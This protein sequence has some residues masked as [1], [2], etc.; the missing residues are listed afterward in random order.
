MRLEQQVMIAAPPEEVWEAICDPLALGQ[1]MGPGMSVE[2]LDPDREPGLGARYR[3]LISVGAAL[4][5][6][7]VEIVEW[8]APRDL[9]WVG[10]TGVSHRLRLRVRPE[11][12]GTRLTLRFAYDAPGILGTVADL[13]ALPRVRRLL[14]EGLRAIKHEVEQGS[15]PPIRP[16]SLPS[17][18]LHELGNVAV[19]ARAGI[20]A[21]MRPDKLPRLALAAYVWGPTLATGVAVGAIRHPERPIVEDE[22]G[23]LSYREMHE[24]TDAIAC[25]LAELGIAEGDS[26]GLMARNHRGFV[27]GAIAVAKLG[28]DVLLLNTAF[29]AP[30]LKEVC[31]RERPSALIYDAEF[32]EL[33]EG[34]AKRRVRVIA[35]EPQD[36]DGKRSRRRGARSNGR[37]E[38]ARGSTRGR[39]ASTLAELRRRHAGSRPLP[40][41]R[42]GRVTILTSGTTGTPKGASRGAGGGG[43]ALPSLDAPAGLLERIPLRAGMRIGLAAPMFHAW[44]LANFALGL[45]LGATHVLAR[46]FDPEAWLERIERSRVQALI[47]VPVMMQRILA[48]PEETR[49]RHD[50]SSLQVVAASGSA[51]P[52]DLS[53]RWMDEF[54]DTLY[55]MYG[56]TEVASATI[57]TPEDMRAA[58]GTAGRPT[59]GTTV[60]LLDEDGHE[61]A[62]GESGRIFV[63]NSALFE[64]YTGGGD[65]QRVAGLASSGDIGRFDEAGRLFVEGRDDEM[66][67]S[68]GENVF[69]K[70]VEDVL[71]RHPAVSEAAAIGVEDE[72]FGQRLRAYVVTSDG[73]S[74]DEDELKKWVRDQLAR[75]KVPREI[76]FIDELPRNATGKVLKRELD[77]D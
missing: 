59:R 74:V 11:A 24:R 52:G 16:P 3:V 21:P 69:P 71:A 38:H 44:G 53:T 13:A 40:P 47:V 43:G 68:G 30:Q 9:A 4:A 66:I 27:E 19:L 37:A 28:A 55:N 22:D 76:R 35:D 57:A 45:G 41:D 23:Q 39:A 14:E 10:F 62:Q 65:K 7:N 50:T 32:E 26:V 58:P 70:E 49:R 15:P 31:E 42:S 36:A 46:K 34:A 12:G 77:S 8:D 54:G 48:L 17:R 5:G 75:Y 29:S 73:R 63:G 1:A 72:D 64:G 20:V 61:V 25:G 60:K 18:L 33:L 6:G 2:A 56:S 51:L 67:V